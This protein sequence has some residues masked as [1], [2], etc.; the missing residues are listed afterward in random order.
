MYTMTMYF[1]MHNKPLGTAV[2]KGSV[3]SCRTVLEDGAAHTASWTVSGK[4]SRIGR[5]KDPYRT[6]RVLRFRSKGKPITCTIL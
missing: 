4:G 1:S 5:V 2:A 3:G 6:S